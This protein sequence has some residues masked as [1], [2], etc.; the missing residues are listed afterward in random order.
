MDLIYERRGANVSRKLLFVENIENLVRPATRFPV[1]LMP[2]RP[3]RRIAARWQEGARG[4]KGARRQDSSTTAVGVEWILGWDIF[5]L[6]S[7]GQSR[8]TRSHADALFT[9]KPGFLNVRG[10]SNGLSDENVKTSL[11]SE[12]TLNPFWVYK[13]YPLFWI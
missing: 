2:M 12:N 11:L 6:L 8:Q 4:G 9:F 10:N 1:P 5:R 13:E 3:M 7:L